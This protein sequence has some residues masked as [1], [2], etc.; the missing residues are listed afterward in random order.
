LKNL[1]LRV[2]GNESRAEIDHSQRRMH[3]AFDLCRGVRR[4]VRFAIDLFRKLRRLSWQ[5]R[6]LLLEAVYWLAVARIAIAVLPFRHVGLL[7]ARPI[8]RPTPPHQVRLK[9]VRG[10]RWAIV[11][12]SERVPWRALCFQQ[13]LAAQLMLRLR[14]V[15]SVLYYG[16][17][18]NDQIGL[19][20][21]VWV[22]DGNVDVIG[23]EIA[24]RYAVLATF[25]PQ[26][27]AHQTNSNFRLR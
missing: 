6:L 27:D 4:A 2:T 11:T 24:S 21:H 7:A 16:A 23:C 19:F 1:P 17:A 18:Q 22:R 12:T 3:I 10:V 15:P 8:R 14:G 25:P 5:D 9:K 26:D 13:G 20:A